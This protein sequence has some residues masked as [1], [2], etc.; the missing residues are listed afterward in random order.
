[1]S[2]IGD[3]KSIHWKLY[4]GVMVHAYKIISRKTIKHQRYEYLVVK[5]NV[6]SW[7]ELDGNSRVRLVYLLVCF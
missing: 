3:A 6:S 4:V 5:F 7:H 2:R 1:M